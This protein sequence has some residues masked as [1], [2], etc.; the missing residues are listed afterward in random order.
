MDAEMEITSSFYDLEDLSIIEQFRRY[1]IQTFG[2]SSRN[3]Y[4]I[5]VVL[6]CSAV[7]GDGLGTHDI[8]DG[9]LTFLALL[10]QLSSKEFI[11]FKRRYAIC[12]WSFRRNLLVDHWLLCE[13]NISALVSGA[14]GKSMTSC[15]SVFV[16]FSFKEAF[17]CIFCKLK[18]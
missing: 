13:I 5:E 10:F 7:E 4:C 2:I 3:D 8:N 9:D 6:R 12:I 14:F 18:T 16:L 11:L 15:K 1:G 17:F